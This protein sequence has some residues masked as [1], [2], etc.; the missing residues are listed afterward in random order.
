MMSKAQN[1]RQ[2][3]MTLVE[4]VVGISLFALVITGLAGAYF[5][6]LRNV[7][8]LTQTIQGSYLAEEGIEAIRSMRDNG[9][10]AS[11]NV[12]V[13]GTTYY[14]EWS[15]SKWLAT[16]VP[17]TTDG[18]F[19]RKFTVETVER[20]ASDDIVASGGTVDSGTKKATVVVSWP[21]QNGTT[22]ATTST[23]FTNLFG[24]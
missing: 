6:Y 2:R 4:A 16:T 12:Y 22:T 24:K 23:Y 20:N 10:S 15:G 7:F 21:S 8:K 17:T 18:I 14:F 3:G 1:Q 13:P 5:Y 9:W 19:Y 11:F